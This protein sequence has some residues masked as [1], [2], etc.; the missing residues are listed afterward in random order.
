MSPESQRESTS[1]STPAHSISIRPWL[2]WAK[3]CPDCCNI[4]GKQWKSNICNHC[5][6]LRC[7]GVWL[8]VP[9]VIQLTNPWSIQIQVFVSHRLTDWHRLTHC[10]AFYPMDQWIRTTHRR[11]Q[12]FS[13]PHFAPTSAYFRDSTS[14]ERLSGWPEAVTTNNLTSRSAMSARRPKFRLTESFLTVPVPSIVK[15]TTFG[16]LGW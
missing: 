8:S 3:D 2:G 15:L 13:L 16:L 5:K 7:N 10:L 12:R 6:W 11:R 9:W 14:V 1:T 4:M